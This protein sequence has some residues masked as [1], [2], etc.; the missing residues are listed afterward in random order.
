M[1]IAKMEPEVASPPRGMTEVILVD[2]VLEEIP[3]P[4]EINS[5]IPPPAPPKSTQTPSTLP[6]PS[7][8]PSR[9]AFLIQNKNEYVG[10]GI[11]CFFDRWIRECKV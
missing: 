10:I 1:E 11:L 9:K 3:D 6:Q 8:S 5:P 4:T 7:A 2:I